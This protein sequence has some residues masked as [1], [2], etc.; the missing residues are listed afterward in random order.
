[1][2]PPF[3][4]QLF[5]LGNGGSL[6]SHQLFLWVWKGPW[7]AESSPGADRGPSLAQPGPPSTDSCNTR[8]CPHS[9]KVG[10]ASA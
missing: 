3:W 10:R 6:V 9:S 7:A 2:P 4:P 1:M 5:H 8:Y